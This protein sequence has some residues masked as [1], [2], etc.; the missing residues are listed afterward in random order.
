MVRDF[1][2]L[3][4]NLLLG[5]HIYRMARAGETEVF[6]NIPRVGRCYTYSNA[7]S[8]FI[9]GDYRYFIRDEPVY[10][11]RFVER[12]MGGSGDG[13]G[14]RHTF[15][16]DGVE[17]TIYEKYDCEAMFFEAPCI[18]RAVRSKGRNQAVRNVY[19]RRTGR[20]AAPGAGPANI[21]RSFGGIYTPK[22]SWG[23]TR[24]KRSKKNNRKT[25]SRN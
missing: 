23:G 24:S 10:V 19:E 2:I 15:N 1:S 17:H 21:I 11:G 6:L 22:G 4:Y 8:D 20:S 14:W 7:R 5:L 18:D 25:R 16:R 12:W 3:V 13:R 9:R